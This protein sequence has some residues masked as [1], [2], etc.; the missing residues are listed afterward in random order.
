MQKL[1]A[2]DLTS[3]EKSHLEAVGISTDAEFWEYIRVTRVRY[4]RAD[5]V[6]VCD[7]CPVCHGI[8]K[9]LARTQ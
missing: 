8:E 2:I 3:E 5:F 7:V 9:R 4:A 1:E 6:D